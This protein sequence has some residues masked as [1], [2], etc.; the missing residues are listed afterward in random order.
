MMLKK[1][2]NKTVLESNHCL[3][4]LINGGISLSTELMGIYE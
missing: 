1:Q 2:E 3:K 4:T